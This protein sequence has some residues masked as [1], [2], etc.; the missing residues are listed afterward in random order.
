M[1]HS[2]SLI[3]PHYNDK[4][5][6]LE[7]LQN[8]PFWS[9]IPN[10]IIIVDSSTKEL[11]IPDNLNLFFAKSEIKFLLLHQKNLFPGHARN[12][13]ITNASNTTLAFLDT[14]THPS[15]EWLLNGMNIIEREGSDGVWG[16]TFFEANSLL[17]KIIRASTYGDKPL[18]TFPGSILHKSAFD[19]CGLF[20]KST[21]AGEDGDWMS[22]AELQ[23]LNISSANDM[24]LYN[25]LNQMSILRLLKKWFRNYSYSSQLPHRQ[26]Q[27]SYYYF[28]VSVFAVLL[29]Y[30]W[31][32]VLAAWDTTSIFYIPNITKISFWLIIGSYILIRGLFLPIKKEVNFRFLLPINFIFIFLLSLA[33]DFTKIFAFVYSKFRTKV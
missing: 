32:R 21:R 25:K 28:G 13:G 22:R 23:G 24:L 17:A 10:E 18:R 33:I 11:S 14:S 31:N 29:A 5:K 27:K 30:N 26:L 19:Q 12:V 20:I 16:K 7:L 8:I 2:I 9:A 6:L 3:I 4:E 1:I 15:N